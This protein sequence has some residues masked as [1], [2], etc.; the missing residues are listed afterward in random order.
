MVRVSTSNTERGIRF[1]LS[2]LV[3]AAVLF[4]LAGTTRW[5][6]AW[7]FL[8]LTGAILVAYAIIMVRVHPDLIEER[9]RPPA[10][11]KAWDKPF[12][13]V[14]GV[15]GPVLFVVIAA[16]DKRFGWSGGMDGWLQ[17]LGLVLVGLGGALSNYAVFTNRFFSAVVRIQVDRGH[18]V[19][20]GGPYQYV[21]HPGY[22][23]SLLHMTGSGFALGSWWVVALTFV[24]DLV[25]V[26]RTAKEDQTLREELPGYEA[27][28]RR[29]VYR[30]IPWVF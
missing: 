23:G 24:I 1:V 11:A 18:T 16:L 6:A 21:R 29:V 28:S 17:G 30:L 8:L 25:L 27:Y 14:I 19:V 9:N 2:I 3:Y 12:V 20:D 4:G 5:P 22:V 26:A 10:D 7:L 15:A 13:A